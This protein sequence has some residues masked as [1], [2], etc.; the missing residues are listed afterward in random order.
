MSEATVFAYIRASNS[1]MPI[2]I[3]RLRL[4]ELPTS[5]TLTANNQMMQS[6]QWREGMDYE[7]VV[8][9]SNSGNAIAQKGDLQ[10][11]F[12]PAQLGDSVDVLID[13]VIESN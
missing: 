3:K 7:W 5:V 13:Q 2:A 11:V 4:A 8:R 9:V 1:H 6:G 10:G 12:S